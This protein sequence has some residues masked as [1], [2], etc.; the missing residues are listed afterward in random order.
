LCKSP[1]ATEDL[2]RTKGGRKDLHT[3][4]AKKS[5]SPAPAHGGCW[6]KQDR[7][8]PRAILHP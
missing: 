6:G 8:L 1:E 2:V 7:P 3:G 5:P 4:R